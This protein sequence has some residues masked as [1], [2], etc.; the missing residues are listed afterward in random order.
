MTAVRRIHIIALYAN[1]AGGA[2]VYTTGLARTLASRGHDV[3][4][5][6]HDAER[7][8][9]PGV[10]IRLLPRPDHEHMPLVWRIRPLLLM[11]Q[12]LR[13]LRRLRLETP[14]VAISSAQYLT[15][16]Y[17]RTLPRV[18]IFYMPHAIVA[19]QLIQGYQWASSLQRRLALAVSARLERQALNAAFRTIRLSEMGCRAMQTFYGDAVSPRF[20][21][22]PAPVDLP[23]LTTR[24]RGR[25]LRL[26]YV[27]RLAETKNVDFLLHT[28]SS[29]PTT[30]WRLDIVGDGEERARLEALA[31]RRDLLG[32]VTFHGHQDEVGR[33]YDAA[34]L[35]VFPSRMESFG[36][37]L[38]EAMSHGLP[39]LTIRHDGVRYANANHEFIQDDVTGLLADGEGAFRERLLDVITYPAPLEAM[40]GR[41]RAIVEQEHTWIAHAER[42]EALMTDACAVR[43][44]S[45]AAH[46]AA[47]RHDA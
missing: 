11:R 3:T 42:L 38:L 35:F 46:A 12:H 18:P 22:L 40:G 47:V 28:L 39:T 9:V 34:D 23:P 36:L 29:L 37:V 30:A 21:V 16:A 27:G 33:Y 24:Q 1:R 32:R 26:L 13:D 43:T 19:P 20:A 5:I 17:A 31:A 25:E 10:R 8:L 2:E 44:P 41:A 7:D 15:W 14:D 4:L 45:A 6:C